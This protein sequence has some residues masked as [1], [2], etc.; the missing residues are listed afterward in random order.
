MDEPSFTESFLKSLWVPQ[1]YAKILIIAISYPIWL[2]I[3]RAMGKEVKDAVNTTA[4]EAAVRR[5]PPK[6]EDPFLNV[7]L[8]RHRRGPG[9]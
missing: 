1:T 4:E 7:P 8:A 5:P 3:L 2:P 6:G 9:R